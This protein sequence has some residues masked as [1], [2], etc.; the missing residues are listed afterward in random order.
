[1]QRI[2][3]WERS[4][5]YV[6]EHGY[7][8]GPEVESYLRTTGNAP[9]SEYCGAFQATA[10]VRCG[11]PIPAGAGG[12]YNWFLLTSPRT[13]FCLGVRGSVDEIQP[14][15]RVGFWNPRL[16]RVGHIACVEIKTR[17]GFV[18]LEGNVKTGVNAGVHR[19]TRGRG[20]I[21]AAANWSY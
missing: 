6:R 10:N 4:Q 2:L 1:M 12:S 17:N 19:L 5:L 16:K 11:L 8:R 9:G 3:D 18:T 15:D 20:E 7:N 13:L 21:Y 14:A